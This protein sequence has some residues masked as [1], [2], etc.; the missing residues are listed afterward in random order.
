M[1]F[2]MPY[3]ILV[4]IAYLIIQATYVTANQLSIFGS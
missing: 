2:K 4:Q 1:V 3:E